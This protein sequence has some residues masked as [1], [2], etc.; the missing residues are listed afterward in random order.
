MTAERQRELAIAGARANVARA[1]RLARARARAMHEMNASFGARIF[2]VE[3]PAYK[4]AVQA[5]ADAELELWQL[6]S[7]VWLSI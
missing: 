7:G 4:A 2:T 5:I 3:N 6:E 1:K